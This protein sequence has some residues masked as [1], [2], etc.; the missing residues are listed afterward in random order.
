MDI[1]RGTS[2]SRQL[3][4]ILHFK[5]FQIKSHEQYYN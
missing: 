1:K 3:H 4:R 2:I 5:K